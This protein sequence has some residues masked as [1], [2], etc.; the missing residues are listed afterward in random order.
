VA[1]ISPALSPSSPALRIPAKPR[2]GGALRRRVEE[3]VNGAVVSYLDGEEQRRL[4]LGQWS[5][6]SRCSAYRSGSDGSS[7]EYSSSSLQPLLARE[8]SEVLGDALQ[9][10]IERG[11][12]HGFSPRAMGTR[13]L[14][15]LYS[16]QSKFLY[17]AYRVRLDDR[18]N[19]FPFVVVP[20]NAMSRRLGGP[21]RSGLACSARGGAG[22]A[23]RGRR[24]GAGIAER[25]AEL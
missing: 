16:S 15:W 3:Q 24:P 11:G 4:A 10:R 1:R 8:R 7:S 20:G 6:R 18:A 9:A 14:T 5:N 21:V 19:E 23:P 13:T 17:R 22:S 25:L 2:V 12:R